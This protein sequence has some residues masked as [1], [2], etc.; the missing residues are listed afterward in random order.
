M[1]IYIVLLWISGWAPTATG[2]MLTFP[3]LN[4]LALYFEGPTNAGGVARTMMLLPVING[5]LCAVYIWTFLLTSHLGEARTLTTICTAL[6][7]ALWIG[8]GMWIAARKRAGR[9]TGIADDAQP[10]YAI[11]ATIIFLTL[12]ASL[13]FLHPR[14]ELSAP[15]AHAGWP[16]VAQ[17]PHELWKAASSNQAKCWLFLIGLVVFVLLSSHPRVAPEVRG[18]MGGFP[19]VPFGGLVSITWDLEL[20]AA[21]TSLQQM[22]GS[23]WASPVVPI[24]FILLF[25][26]TITHTRA[27]PIQGMGLLLGWLL[28]LV[29]IAGISWLLVRIGAQG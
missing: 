3:T 20:D 12:A 9:A 17:V 27:R 4:G 8:S 19:I 26:R 28:C 23:V 22:A 21:L 25:T 16:G 29:A 6:V 11:L 18:F 24:W 15:G 1:A 7:I 13:A 2:L 10:R 5:L 14:P